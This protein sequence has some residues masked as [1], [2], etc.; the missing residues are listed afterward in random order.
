MTFN[1]LIWDP[2]LLG[3]H[4]VACLQLLCILYLNLR[5]F[6][7]LFWKLT[8][9][10]SL[11][12]LKNIIVLQNILKKDCCLFEIQCLLGIIELLVCRCC[13]LIKSFYISY[14]VILYLNRGLFLSLF[15]KLTCKRSLD[16]FFKEKDCCLFEIQCLLGIIEL[17]VCRCCALIRSQPD[18][19]LTSHYLLCYALSTWYSH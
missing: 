14:Q 7:S 5:L 17:L 8:C 11:D 12:F 15:S 10:G 6:L 4:W 3:N 19:A 9:K 13:A 2:L 16:F 1:R 18:V